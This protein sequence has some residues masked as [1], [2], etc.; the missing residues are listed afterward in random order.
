MNS[1][2]LIVLCICAAIVVDLLLRYDKPKKMPALHRYGPNLWQMGNIRL[3]RDFE[4]RVHARRLNT[5]EEIGSW[6]DLS[7]A[8][9][10]LIEGGFFNEK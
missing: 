6:D 3:E 7:Q 4:G 9:E 8:I 5:L 1:I 10:S 2:E